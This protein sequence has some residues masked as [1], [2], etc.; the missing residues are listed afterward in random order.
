MRKFSLMA[1]SAS[2]ACAVIWAAD[3]PGQSGNPQRD[4][5]A[6]AEKAFTKEN[7]GKIEF[8]YKYKAENQ[9]KGLSALGSPV[10][11]GMLITYLGFKEMLVFGGSS[12][13]VYSVDADLARLIW[14][15]H[16]DNKSDKA[17][18]APTAVCPGGMTAAIAMPGSSTAGGRGP[19]GGGRG[20]GP[21]APGAA[22]PGRGPGAPAAGRGAAP[23][24]PAPGAPQPLFAAGNFGR[25]ANFAA[26][27]SDGNLHALNSSTGGDRATP[28]KFVP[29]NS[30]VSGLNVNDGVV[31]AATQD[32]CGGNANGIYALDLSTLEPKASSME[33]NGGGA[34]GSGGTAV[35]TDGTVYA[36]IP[37][38]TGE[39]AGKY[40]DTVI[41]MSKDLKV[42][43]Y[44]TPSSTVSAVTKGIPAPGATPVVFSWKG[45]DVIVAGGRDGRLYLLDSKSLGGADHHTPLSMT[46]PVA[47][48]DTKFAG[49]GFWGT[50]ASWED[51]DNGNARWVYASLWGP[52]AGSAK[53]GATNGNAPNGSI[54]AFKVEEQ[55][56]KP[57]LTPAWSSRDMQAPAPVVT[58]NGLVFALSSGE[59]AR[60]AKENGTPYTVAEKQKMAGRAVLYVLDGA[61]GKE[62]Y[63][64]GNM[65]ATFSHG[66]GIA[67]A[68]R[69]IY[70]TTHDNLMYAL[71]FLAEQPQL[72]G[73]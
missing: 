16:F 30:K 3:W 15:V 12:D 34:A 41:A 67:V 59:S 25:A 40:N 71:G 70:F 10:I 29:P 27:G 73:K 4:G 72:T 22:G 8:L 61:T 43:D 13:N 54:V 28:I 26:I 51:T 42:K 20:R 66:T 6:K 17:A 50:F 36:Q 64:S 46:E 37:D 31:Y 69:R 24:F 44:F 68:N 38:G 56:G 48:P 60:Q 57:V 18:P 47:S 52:A 11:N 1:L 32:S 9:A 45:S 19:G 49:N 33:L 58:A 5:W 65:T 62:L 55:G 14:K 7:A 53:F 63:S 39:V 23:A 21:G 35:G 2:V